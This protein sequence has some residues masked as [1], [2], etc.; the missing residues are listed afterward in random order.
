MKTK[1]DYALLVFTYENESMAVPLWTV[2]ALADTDGHCHIAT[3]YEGTTDSW[4]ADES[5]D[6]ILERYLTLLRSAA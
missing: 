3:A 4:T 6:V 1:L 2:V 5:F